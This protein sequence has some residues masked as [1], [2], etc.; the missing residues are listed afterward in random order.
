M[1]L[2]LGRTYVSAHTN[3]PFSHVWAWLIWAVVVLLL[4]GRYQAV[5]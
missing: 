5:F 3:N 4:I 1:Y 2:W